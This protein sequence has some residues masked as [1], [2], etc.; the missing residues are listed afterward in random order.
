MRVRVALAIRRSQSAAIVKSA[1]SAVKTTGNLPALARPVMGALFFK[2]LTGGRQ[3]N[4][5]SVSEELSS[6]PGKDHSE[7]TMLFIGDSGTKVELPIEKKEV[8]QAIKVQGGF[9]RRCAF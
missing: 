5:T 3:P 9:V 8:P 4:T 2:I 1:K 6:L 7:Q